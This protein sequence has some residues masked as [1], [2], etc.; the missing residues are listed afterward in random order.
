MP[1]RTDIRKLVNSHFS[2]DT[3]LDMLKGFRLIPTLQKCAVI[4]LMNGNIPS[5]ADGH[6]LTDALKINNIISRD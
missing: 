2:F 4:Y 1:R 5:K 3:A 6:V